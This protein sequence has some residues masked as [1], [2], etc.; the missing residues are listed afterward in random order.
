VLGGST[1]LKGNGMVFA[2][3][4]LRRH[5]WT[6]SLTEDIEYHMRLILAGERAM[7]A[8]DAIVWAEMPDSLRTAQTQNERWERGRMEMI[9]H[10]VPHLLREGLRRRSF[11]LIDAAIEQLIPPFSVVTGLSILVLF[12]ALILRDPSALAMASFILVG[13]IIYILSGLFLVRAPWPIYRSLL[14]TPFFIIWK[15]WL[16]VRLLLGI[17]PH[18]WIRT[19]RNRAPKS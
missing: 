11:L 9:R 19:A 14:F 12:I 3:D 10:Y 13:Q 6:A 7:F 16:Y 4:I 1:G 8:P 17:K 2:A 18:D 15:L 5:R